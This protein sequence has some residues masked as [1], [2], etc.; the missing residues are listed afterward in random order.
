[1][2][3]ADNKTAFLNMSSNVT[4][5]YMRI[6]E[7]FAV[8]AYKAAALLTVESA[9]QVQT[10]RIDSLHVTCASVKALWWLDAQ[11]NLSVA[12]KG[13]TFRANFSL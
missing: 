10:T 7:I 2:R 11:L 4:V 1:M 8:C 13:N 6:T 12:V 9:P 3:C 5:I